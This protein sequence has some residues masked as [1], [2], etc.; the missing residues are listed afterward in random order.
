MNLYARELIQAWAATFP[1]DQ[2]VVVGGDWI[3]RGVSF[4]SN[5]STRVV[6]RSSAL[7]R[8][9]TQWTTSALLARRENADVLLSLSPIASALRTRGAKAVVVHDWRHMRRPREFPLYQRAYR[10]LWAAS[11]RRANVVIAVS[12]KTASET[13]QYIGPLP[14]LTVVEN[15]GDHA[16]RWSGQRAEASPPRIITFGHLPNKRPEGV[17]EALAQL[18]L[19]FSTT[20]L[21]VLGATRAYGAALR[22]LAE[23]LGVSDRVDLPG[24][25][26]DS[27]YERLVLGAALI[28]L[29]SSDEGYGLPV[30]EGR[31]L[32]I[33][34]AAALDSGLGRIH[35]IGLTVYDPTTS[36]LADVIVT[37]L[38][39]VTQPDLVRTWA[40][41]AEEIRSLFGH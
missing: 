9:R 2:L 32:G 27:E 37:A 16:L 12:E 11:I 17:I 19:T 22:A 5:V 10:R 26:S 29:N 41:C 35:G 13:R 21:V 6:R 40:Q 7:A 25:V 38:T 39:H 1:G 24:F 20:R 15:G 34:V 31:S 18:P 4:S 33:P 30:A 3:R 28:V 23:R 8:L 14:N 36:A